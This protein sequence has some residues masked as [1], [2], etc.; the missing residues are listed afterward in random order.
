MSAQPFRILP[1]CKIEEVL[2]KPPLSLAHPL[3]VGLLH[4]YIVF[5][6]VYVISCRIVLVPKT[7]TGCNKTAMSL[8]VTPLIEEHVWAVHPCVVCWLAPMF[9][10]LIRWS[11]W[12]DH[13][14]MVDGMLT[15]SYSLC[16]S[17]AKVQF[18]TISLTCVKAIG[19]SNK[20]LPLCLSLSL[21]VFCV[22]TLFLVRWMSLWSDEY[23]LRRWEAR[24][25][26]L[27]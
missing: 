26:R 5:I 12:G 23:I 27:V 17:L 9:V 18:E 13:A 25:G 11:F 4:I 8:S 2:N 15:C 22:V 16:L 20:L 24:C 6:C 3:H 7:W 10:R 21:S 14:Y 19:Q 1:R